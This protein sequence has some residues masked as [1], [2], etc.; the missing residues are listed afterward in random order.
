MVHKLIT[1]NKRSSLES[2]GT[3]QAGVVGCGNYLAEMYV[4]TVQDLILCNPN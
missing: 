1:N 2:M 4:I 3:S